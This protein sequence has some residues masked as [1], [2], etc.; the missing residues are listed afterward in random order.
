MEV[1]NAAWRG[2]FPLRLRLFRQN[3]VEDPAFDPEGLW[4]ARSHRGGPPVGWCVAKAPPGASAG[5]TGWVSALV[6]RPDCQGRGVGTALLRR[7]E[8]YLRLRGRGRAVL[9]GDPS[10]FFPGVPVDREGRALGFF[11]SRGY[12]LEGTA[13][14]LHRPIT[15][16]RTPPQVESTLRAHPDLQIRPLRPGEDEPLLMFL[17][18]VFPGRWAHD[19][20]RSLAGGDV[21]DIVGV[22]AGRAV[23][24]FA[25][26][27]HPGSSRI[28][29]SV[30]WPLGGAR[31]GGVGPLGIA[32]ALRGRGLGLA[33]LDRAVLHLR[34]RDVTDVV[35]DWTVLLDFYGRLGFVP[36]REY[37]HGRRDLA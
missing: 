35:V 21:G 25:H 3:T 33:L 16:Y 5:E 18:Q 22:L 11:R 8:A 12:R 7:A 36:I 32:P 26:T 10:H 6:V 37:R 29:P 2:A 9:G 1:W 24:G 20:E 13:Y 34:R 4:I 15:A 14:D 30:M 19:V 17:A 27:F 28:G 31:L 23:V